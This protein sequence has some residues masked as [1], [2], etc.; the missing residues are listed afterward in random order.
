MICTRIQNV[1]NGAFKRV[2]TPRIQTS[3][4]STHFRG[5]KLTFNALAWPA[6]VQGAPPSIPMIHALSACTEPLA[7][8]VCAIR[9]SMYESQDILQFSDGER[10]RGECK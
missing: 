4:H 7:S 6:V 8:L 10:A 9:L 2:D 5:S 3:R 1:Q